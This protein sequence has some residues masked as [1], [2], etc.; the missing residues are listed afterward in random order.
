MVTHCYNSYTLLEARISK[1]FPREAQNTIFGIKLIVE[2]PAAWPLFMRNHPIFVLEKTWDEKT[3]LPKTYKLQ[4]SDSQNKIKAEVHQDSGK[5]GVK[6]TINKSIPEFEKGAKKVNLDY[7]HSFMEFENVLQGQYK[8]A[9][10]QVV[11]EHF[12]EPTDPENVP[13]KQ[14]C[15]SD[16]N[17]C[18]AVELFITKV[19]HKKKPR[20]WQ[21]IYM[22]PG[23]NH[24]IQK[25]IKMSPLNHLYG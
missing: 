1:T 17:F 10:K 9:W 25:K 11:H 2:E 6:I 7:A 8:T 3:R 20:D 22:M 21:Y 13:V 23:G 18:C 19:L 16:A 4:S 14:V 15:S 12:P 24:N 5:L